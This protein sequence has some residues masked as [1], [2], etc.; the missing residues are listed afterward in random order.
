M[1]H[2]YS[3][4]EEGREGNLKSNEI[5]DAALDFLRNGADV[6]GEKDMRAHDRFVF[7]A[8]CLQETYCI[9][10]EANGRSKDNESTLKFWGRVLK[11]ALAAIPVLAAVAGILAALGIF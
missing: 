6:P 5:F 4:L 7:T 3:N 1:Y 8:A 10:S 2:H 9:A 11:G